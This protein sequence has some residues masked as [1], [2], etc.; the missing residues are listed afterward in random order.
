MHE[1]TH[2]RR[3]PPDDTLARSRPASSA[4]EWHAAPASE[5]A[6][7][8][9]SHAKRRL[10]LAGEPGVLARTSSRPLSNVRYASNAIFSDRS[11]IAESNLP[12]DGGKVA[13]VADPPYCIAPT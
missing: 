11:V 10:Q 5:L 7:R 9:R 4:R 6:T 12:A 13:A 1:Q 2:R 8:V 3:R